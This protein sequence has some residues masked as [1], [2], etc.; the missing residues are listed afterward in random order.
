MP[1]QEPSD[2]LSERLSHGGSLGKRRVLQSVQN[3]KPPSR[4]NANIKLAADQLAS[5]LP[6][7]APQVRVCQEA[8]HST[9]Q[10]VGSL[11]KISCLTGTDQ[12]QMH[13]DW[14]GDDR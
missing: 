9:R 8:L 14:V 1:V 12:L 13:A 7:P 11:N 5:L 10:L 3:S 2:R 6:Q 4:A